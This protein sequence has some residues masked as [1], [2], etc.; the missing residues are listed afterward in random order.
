MQS[1]P[2][3]ESDLCGSAD[4]MIKPKHNLCFL[5]LCA[6]AGD[7]FIIHSGSNLITTWHYF[8]ESCVLCAFLK[9]HYLFLLLEPSLQCLPHCGQRSNSF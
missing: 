3:F 7:A 8:E 2:R 1:V 5:D 4:I 9:R 6:P